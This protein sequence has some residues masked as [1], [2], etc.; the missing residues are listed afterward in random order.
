MTLDREALIAHAGARLAEHDLVRAVAVAGADANGRA[1][2]RSDVDLLI[3]VERGQVDATIAA[4]RQ[5]IEELSPIAI[6]Y[7]VPAPAH[8]L[9]QGFWQLARAAEHTMVDWVI[10][11]VHRPEWR[12]FMERERHG[13]P[14]VLFDRDGLVVP[15]SIDRV[16]L[17]EQLARRVA[18]LRMRVP[19]YAHM[20]VKLADRGEGGLPIDAIHFYHSLVLRPLVDMLRIVHCPERHDFGLRYLKDDLPGELYAALVPLSYPRGPEALPELTA[21]ARALFDEALAA[22]DRGKMR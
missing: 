20:P 22:W 2:E 15:T 5:A 16:A 13:T 8:G 11:E 14:R 6:D 12:A 7:R 10:A 3:L 18:E 9:D 21:R 19:L 1:D 17:A 4:L